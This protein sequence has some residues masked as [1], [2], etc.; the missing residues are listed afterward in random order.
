[1]ISTKLNEGIGSGSSFNLRS[2][3]S[4]KLGPE[5][6]KVLK[7]KFLRVCAITHCQITDA[8]FNNIT[9]VLSRPLKA[10]NT[11]PYK[12]VI[13]KKKKKEKNLILPKN[14]IKK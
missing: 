4:L 8:S 5:F 10:M 6:F 1:M 13:Q 3:D 2:T 12:K 9:K 14:K 11:F 7:G